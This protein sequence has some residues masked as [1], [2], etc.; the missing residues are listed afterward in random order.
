MSQERTSQQAANRPRILVLHGPNLNLLGTREPEVYGRT[1][2]ADI[3][4][5]LAARATQAGAD[6]EHFQ[7]NHEGELIDRVQAARTQGVD[8]ILI[9]PGAFTHTS[10][11]L[12]DALAGVA[13]PFIEVHLSNIHKR[14]PFRHHSYLSDLAVGVICG[15]GAKGYALALDY[16]LEAVAAKPV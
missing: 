4:A 16:A 10:V 8:F 13:I 9:N 2:L 11:A 15:L 5:G 14:E 1:T 6:L 12:R 3:D 7:S